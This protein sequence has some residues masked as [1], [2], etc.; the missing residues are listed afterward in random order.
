MSQGESAGIALLETFM[1][2]YR[3]PDYTYAAAAE[4]FSE[5]FV[6]NFQEEVLYQK[7]VEFWGEG[8]GFFDAKRIRPGV[9]TWYKGSN[10][11]HETLKYNIE[12][13]SPFWNF[14]IPEMEFEVN[15]YIVK[16]DD[17]ATEI[18]GVMTTLNNP[19]PT[20]KVET[21]KTQF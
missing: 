6:K 19:D 18:D 20:G 4:R 14:V 7:R 5:G 1:K 16:E 2:S 3:D 10:V 11:I 9:K 15:D 12:E 21:D 17:I 13:V 8:V